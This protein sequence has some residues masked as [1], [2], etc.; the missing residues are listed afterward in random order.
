MRVQ[1]DMNERYIS[2][3]LFVYLYIY[4]YLAIQLY[5]HISI[6]PSI[7]LPSCLPVCLPVCLAV[8]LSVDL[9][10]CVFLDLVL[11]FFTS[12]RLD[13]QNMY[14]MLWN[15]WLST[16]LFLQRHV[17]HHRRRLFG[18]REGLGIPQLKT[19]QKCCNVGKRGQQRIADYFQQF[20]QN[21]V[22]SSLHQTFIIYILHFWPLSPDPWESCGF[23]FSFHSVLCLTGC[24][25]TSPNCII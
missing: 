23:Y 6:Y 18:S 12:K 8:C 5:I 15:N 9:E 20:V 21:H 16:T 22:L 10:S 7:H 1:V 19:E 4:S 25:G 17:H 14:E 3:Y 11:S 2:I 13:N 24:A